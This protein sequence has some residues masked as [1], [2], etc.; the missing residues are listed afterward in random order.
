MATDHAAERC[1]NREG[2]SSSVVPMQPRAR[3]QRPNTGPQDLRGETGSPRS[4]AFS[5]SS[6]SPR[7]ILSHAR[8]AVEPRVFIT[9]EDDVAVTRQ[10]IASQEGPVILVTR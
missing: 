5:P 7:V 2:P 10:V 3:S 6:V 8:H 9:L 1:T 4:L